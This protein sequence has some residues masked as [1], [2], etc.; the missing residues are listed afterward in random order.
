M[1]SPMTKQKITSPTLQL[2]ITAAQHERAVRSNSGGCLI[3]DAIKEQYPHLSGVVVDMATIRV[4][5]R[6]KG[7]RYTYLTPPIAQHVLLSFDQGW[8]N[9][10]EQ[11]TIRRA[12]KIDR[13][14]LSPARA[15]K[16]AATRA[17]RIS[18]LT[19]KKAAGVEL[20]PN[21]KKAL[22]RMTGGSAAKAAARPATRGPVTEVITTGNQP[23]TVIGGEPLP[24]GQPHP[25]LLRGR[26]RIFGAKL[27]DPGEAFREAVAQAAADLAK[28]DR[29]AAADV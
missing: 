17:Q 7:L 25:N 22:T 4:T 29:P 3:A 27:A 16:R 15:K 19:T 18:E 28:Q 12:V 23:A 24:Q 26:N 8:T 10:A 2:N 11:L 9:P 13:L 20:T 6:A 14:T 1:S 21:E 5:D